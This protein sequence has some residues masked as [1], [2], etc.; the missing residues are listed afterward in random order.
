MTEYGFEIEKKGDNPSWVNQVHGSEYI[1]VKG[2]SAGALSSGNTPEADAVVTAEGNKEIWVYTADCI[3]VLV[4][5]KG[6]EPMVG[7]I[8]S[9]WRGTMKGIVSK[10][11]GEHFSEGATWKIGPAIGPCCFAVREDFIDTFKSVRG[12]VSRYLRRVESSWKFDLISFLLNEELG[13]VKKE[14]IDL[15]HYRCT[16]CSMPQLPS[17]RR[18]GNTNSR[19]R[20]WIRMRS[21]YQG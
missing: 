10:I 21:R 17:Y 20:A 6:D 16:L 5:K 13:G 4:E 7:A 9:G 1:V 19:I 14:D 18:E 8:H 12:D 11:R 15:T 2:E 3:P